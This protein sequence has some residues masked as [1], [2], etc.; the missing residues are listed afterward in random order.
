MDIKDIPQGSVV[1]MYG[2]PAA[3]KTWH[4]LDMVGRLHT[5]DK[6]ALAVWFDVE[7]RMDRRDVSDFGVD[8]QRFHVFSVNGIND[9]EDCFKGVIQLV[10]DGAPNKLVVINSVTGIATNRGADDPIGHRA[11]VLELMARRA[12]EHN[13]TLVLVCQVRKEMYGFVGT[14]KVPVPGGMDLVDYRVAISS[15]RSVEVTKVEKEPAN[16]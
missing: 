1:A 5:E 14:T 10:K 16:G 11:R 15:A 12:R 13:V 2:P 8:P 3:G 6:E 4:A 7:Y 9:V